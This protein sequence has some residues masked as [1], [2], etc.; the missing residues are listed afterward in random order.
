MPS[1]MTESGI[2]LLLAMLA[3]EWRATYMDKGSGL[4]TREEIFLSLL[5]INIIALRY[6]WRS[7]WFAFFMMGS[8]Y[9]VVWVEGYLLIIS[10]MHFSH[11]M[12]SCCPVFFTTICQYS[13]LQI[14]F[15]E[16]CHIDERHA[17]CVER[18][19]EHISR[20]IHRAAS[21]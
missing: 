2:L 1:L 7:F 14:L 16:V 15:A 21:P 5:F 17:S 12:L 13:I 6:C 4:F 18:K 20:K 3:H 10:C 19:H 9:S 11:L 8:M